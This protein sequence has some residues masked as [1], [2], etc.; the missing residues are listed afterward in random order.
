MMI[1]CFS[2]GVQ[3]PLLDQWLGNGWQIFI[4]D[5]EQIGIEEGDGWLM[6][7]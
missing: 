4:I 1:D 5:W 6:V 3:C 7:D 2:N